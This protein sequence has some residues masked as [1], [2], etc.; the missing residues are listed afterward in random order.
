MNK[1]ERHQQRRIRA[2]T[3]A[4]M[5]RVGFSQTEVAHQF[6]LTRSRIG[7]ILAGGCPDFDLPPP[8]RSA[9]PLWSPQAAQ[10]QKQLR[11]PSVEPKENRPEWSY[12]D[13]ITLAIVREGAVEIERALQKTKETLP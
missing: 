1:H 7:Q 2:F 8:R 13:E 11:L 5:M 10:P 6:G 4:Q 12:P 3:V 9:K